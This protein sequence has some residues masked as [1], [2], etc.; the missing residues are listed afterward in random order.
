MKIYIT[1]GQVHTHSISGKTLDKDCVAVI[2]AKD[3]EAARVKAIEYF[4]RK[5]CSMYDEQ[6]FMITNWK[7]YYPRGLI[8]I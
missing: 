7:L 6:S 5:Y 4:G 3:F 8:K 1:F 2:E